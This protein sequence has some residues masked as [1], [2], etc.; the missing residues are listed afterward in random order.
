MQMGLKEYKQ[1]IDEEM[2]TILGQLDSAS[3][4]YDHVYLVRDSEILQ[5]VHY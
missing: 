1:Y 5:T 3:L 4:I 2:L